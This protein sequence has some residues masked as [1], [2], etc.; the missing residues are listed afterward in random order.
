MTDL[1]LPRLIFCVT[2]GRSG[3]TYLA[4]LLEGLNKTVSVH[5][6]KPNFVSRMR[7]VQSNR[8]EAIKFWE[9]KKIPAIQSLGCNFY[10][11]TSHLFCKG[12]FEPLV[13]NYQLPNLIILRR[14]L[15]QVAKSLTKLNTIPGR[16]KSG[17]RWYLQPSDPVLLKIEDSKNLN[18]Y[19]I[20][21][22]YCLEIEARS[23]KYKE[24]VLEK[25]GK[26][27][28]VSLDGLRQGD[29]LS[30][31]ILELGLPKMSLWLRLKK[32]FNKR[33]K[34]N[35]STSADANTYTSKL[36]DLDY[37][38]LEQEVLSAIDTNMIDM[39]K[40]IL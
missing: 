12:F 11:E 6:A 39:D 36:D 14:S 13:E 23:K 24:I 21:Y 28:E 9:E 40:V 15:R 38:K 22:W 2:P 5:E 1:K 18:D 34:K 19:Q 32:L 25:G 26:V 33:V 16:T 4:G 35:A 10:I 7:R 37:E 27:T 17:L 31:L 29:D 8:I 20:C 3:T 30:R